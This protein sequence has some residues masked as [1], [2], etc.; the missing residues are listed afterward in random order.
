M[1]NTFNVIKLNDTQILINNR[2]EPGLIFYQNHP[3]SALGIIKYMFVNMF[4]NI[5]LI[6]HMLHLGYISSYCAAV[7]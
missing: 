4:Q 3:G 6:S 1:M 2:A 7:K 5:K